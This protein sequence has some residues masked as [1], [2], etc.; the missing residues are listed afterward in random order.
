MGEEYAICHRTGNGLW[1]EFQQCR[2]LVGV[3]RVDLCRIVEHD[4]CLAHRVALLCAHSATCH[5]HRV[6][7]GACRE[8][9]SHTR[10]FVTLVVVAD[11]AAEVERVGGVGLECVEN[12]NLH[13][14][15]A[16]GKCR[17]LLH[18]GRYEELLLLVG[19]LHIL[20]KLNID[21][22]LVKVHCAI[23]RGDIH[24]HRRQRVARPTL[25]TRNV[26]ATPHKGRGKE[27]DHNASPHP[28]RRPF[29]TFIHLF[30]SIY[31]ITLIN[32]LCSLLCSRPPCYSFSA[33]CRACN[34]PRISRTVLSSSGCILLGAISLSGANT[35]S[36]SCIS[37]WGITRSGVLITLSS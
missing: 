12:I 19:E 21:S 10:Q 1:F 32:L 23:G 13:S 34:S 29:H 18:C 4:E 30:C 28:Q 16:Y 2:V 3:E 22:L 37:G 36:L 7:G 20:V 5:I 9:V 17:L 6:D 15:T 31:L 35:N 25:R 24:N 27:K 26:R 8:D 11:T 33:N 14:T